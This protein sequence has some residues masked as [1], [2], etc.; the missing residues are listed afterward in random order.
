MFR[1]FGHRTPIQEGLMSY[2]K[3]IEQGIDA[4]CYNTFSTAM[5]QLAQYAKKTHCPDAL[6]LLTNIHHEITDGASDRILAGR[7]CPSTMS[8]T[9]INFKRFINQQPRRRCS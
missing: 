4:A 2:K 1:F 3:A 9:E 8:V 6:Q 7:L 5:S